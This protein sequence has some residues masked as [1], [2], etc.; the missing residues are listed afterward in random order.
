MP[1][2]PVQQDKGSPITCMR[3][4]AKSERQSIFQIPGLPGKVPPPHMKR[5]SEQRDPPSQWNSQALRASAQG[6]PLALP[7]NS[8]LPRISH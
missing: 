5:E 4:K 2:L 7:S 1:I 3:P 6:I 8:H